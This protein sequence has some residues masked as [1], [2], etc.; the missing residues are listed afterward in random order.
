MTIQQ[1]AS[2]LKEY[3]VTVL[4][5]VLSEDFINRCKDNIL[6]YFND[7]TNTSKGYR[8]VGQT[9]KS[10]GFNYEGLKVKMV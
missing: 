9:I 8:T 3:G 10:N 7:E 5:N 4:P 6:N 1:H 2:D